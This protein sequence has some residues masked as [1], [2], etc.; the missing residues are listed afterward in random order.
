MQLLTFV[1]RL[2]FH[3]DAF[4]SI[5]ESCGSSTKNC[6]HEA[7]PSLRITDNY[8]FKFRTKCKKPKFQTVF[9]MYHWTSLSAVLSLS[10]PFNDRLT[11][12][13]LLK[14]NGIQNW[15]QILFCE[16][17]VTST[18]IL[19]IGVTINLKSKSLAFWA[20]ECFQT[21]GSVVDLDSV[22]VH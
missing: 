9:S 19:L 10:K 21:S 3:S 13:I 22:I 5:I 17:S 12:F 15:A 6:E 7:K 4:L 16:Y 2:F 11:Q 20:R 1:K 18:Y 14:N 8:R